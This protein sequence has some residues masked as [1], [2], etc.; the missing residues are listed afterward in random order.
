MNE[1]GNE[2]EKEGQKGMACRGG[3]QWEGKA[4]VKKRKGRE[5]VK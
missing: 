2:R 5:L 4:K 3:R 1:R